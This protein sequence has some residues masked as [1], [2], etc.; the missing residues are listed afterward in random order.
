[1]I[2]IKVKQIRGK[3]ELPNIINKGDWIDLRC[4][5]KTTIIGPLK[6]KDNNAV[7]FNNTLIPL[8]IAMKLP[9]GYE[10]IVCPRSSTYKHYGVI[11]SNS[12][13]VIDNSYC[14]NEDEWIMP[15]IAFK[16][17]TIPEGDRICQFRIQLSQKAT[18]WQKIKWLF[19]SKISIDIVDDL[20]SDNRGGFGST[21]NK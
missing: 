2:K 10:A 12:I 13:G 11:Q 1:M 3:I 8:G 9:K 16:K 14:G 20:N 18:I 21:G 7:T 17:T 19:T 6:Q 4:A 5:K 15:V